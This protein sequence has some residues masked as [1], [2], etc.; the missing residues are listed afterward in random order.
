MPHEPRQREMAAT[1]TPAP[2]RAGPRIEQTG[3]VAVNRGGMTHLDGER[4][5]EAA[6]AL[7]ELW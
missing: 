1:I 3:E 5:V 6:C 7:R 2:A 4:V